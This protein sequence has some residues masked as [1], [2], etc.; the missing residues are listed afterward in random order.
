MAQGTSHSVT[1][2]CDASLVDAGVGPPGVGAIP[3][4]RLLYHVDLARIGGFSHPDLALEAGG[5][6]TVGRKEPLFVRAAPGARWRPLEDPTISREQIQVRW[7]AADG[8][9]EVAPVATARRALAAIDP[10]APGRRIAIE[11]PTRLPP[12]TC[13][14]I[15][16]RLLLGLEVVPTAHGPDEE[17]LGLVGESAAMW[18]LRQEI[19]EVA[20]FR[21]PALILGETGS[22]KELVAAAI[23]R[24]SP[25]RGGPFQTLNCA[26]LPEHLVESLLFGHARG[27]FTG[28]QSAQEGIF[29]AADGGALFL[30]ELG[31]MPLSVQP[32]LLRTLQDGQVIGLGQSR[33]VAVDVRLIAATHRDPAREI[34]AGRLRADLYHRLAAHVV[35]V[36]PLRARRFDAPE[37]FVRFLERLGGEH[38]AIAWLFEPERWRPTAPLELFV[39]LVAG[40]WPGNVRELENV[41]ERAARLNLGGRPFVAPSMASSRPG[42]EASPTGGPEAAPAAATP[43]AAPEGD[44]GAPIGEEV[45]ATARRLGI[46]ARTLAKIVD[47]EALAAVVAA[48]PAGEGEAA[49]TGRL[50]GF[51]GER[52]HAHLEAE[53][54]AQARVAERL[55]VSAWTL[56]RMMDRFD[57]R[58][59]TEL[60]S[61]EIERALADAGGDLEAAARSLEISPHGLKKRLA[62]LGRGR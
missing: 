42:E 55:G 11:G 52:L 39:E 7:L 57:L 29:R 4:L 54:F 34:A 62:A 2:T 53:G 37:L 45:R 51:V 27:A 47:A 9:F 61:E 24:Q 58:R 43:E 40:A 23:H 8:C 30:D 12:G 6:R 10:G 1:E 18:R 21:K 28:A 26:A 46:V 13:V 31:E 15:E 38:P 41:A 59:P 22:G 19:R 32:K 33:G 14:A 49:L 25:R 3:R 44:A 56:I 60:S 35:E 5:W 50:E 17:R 20:E 36:P 16:E 48:G